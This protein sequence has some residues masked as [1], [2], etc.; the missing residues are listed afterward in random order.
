VNTGRAGEIAARRALEDAGF[1]VHD[2]NIL[3]GQNCANIDLVVFGE[4]A[5]VY[6]QVKTSTK[7]ATKDY[8]TACGAPWTKEQLYDSAPVFNKHRQ[9]MIASFVLL[10]DFQPSG[11]AKFF[12]VPPKQLEKLLRPISRAYMD[13]LKRDGTRRKLI[14]KELPRNL[15]RPWLNAW[16]LLVPLSQK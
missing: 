13:R 16:H 1:V 4:T 14:R 5:A 3:F 12:L 15:L 10:V 11:S 2:A 9:A 8:V 6:I 7:P